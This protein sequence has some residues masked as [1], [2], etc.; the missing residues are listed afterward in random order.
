MKMILPLLFLCC[1]IH[2][3][4]AQL[5]VGF[6]NSS[7]PQTETIIQQAVQKQFNSDRSITAALLRMHFHDCFVRGCDA[8]ILIKST[9]SKKSERDAGPNQTVRGFELIDTIKKS[10][11]TAC[12]STVSCADIITLATR[13]AVALAGGPS[14]AIPT[15]RRDGLVSN[16]ADVNLPGPSLTVS[17]ALQSF[18]NQG[19][20]LNDMVTLLGA[21]TVGVAHCN[22]FQNRLSPVADKTMDPALAAQLLKTCAKSTATAFLDQNTSFTVDNQ[23]FRQIMLRKGILNIDQDLTLDKSSA[24]IVSSLAANDNVFRQSFAN[25]MIK[26]ASIDILVGSAGNIRKNCGVFNPPNQ[27]VDHKVL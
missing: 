14:Y 11:E 21:H 10:L 27:K 26:M 8:S 2:L 12:P 9:K 6:Y 1:V 18:T 22:F 4:S 20:S 15:G 13:D 5:K 24:P 19:L 16:E 7:C 17:Q 25:A 23:F 3:V